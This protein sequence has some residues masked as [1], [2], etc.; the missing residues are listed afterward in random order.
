MAHVKKTFLD[1]LVTYLEAL[2]TVT[3]ATRQLLPPAEARK[4]A[5]YIG[6]LDNNEEL[7]LEDATHV[8]FETNVDLIM[9]CFGDN[10]EEMLDS[11]KTAVYS[12]DMATS[13]QVADIRLI[14]DEP[15]ILIDEDRYSSVR[16]ALNITYWVEKGSF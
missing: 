3:K 6:I 5:P 10:M 13:I 9:L 15:V 1:A 8:R 11:I 7:V 16:V 12:G 4:W 2:S 14:G